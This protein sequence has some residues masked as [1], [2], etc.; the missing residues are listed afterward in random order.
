MIWLLILSLIIL[1][2]YSIYISQKDVVFFGKNETNL[3]R[4][5]M[6]DFRYE[7]FPRTVDI[8]NSYDCNIESLKTCKLDDQTSLFG[9]RE[10]LVKCVHFDKDTEFNNGEVVVPK[11]KNTNE[12]Y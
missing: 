12:G 1:I 6:P 5:S 2:I 9:C 7:E 10:L 4:Y 3:T 11:N 8:E